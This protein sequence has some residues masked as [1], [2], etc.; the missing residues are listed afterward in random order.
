MNYTLL[1]TPIGTL[2][3]CS[4]RSHLTAIEFPGQHGD[5]GKQPLLEGGCLLLTLLTM[6]PGDDHGARGERHHQD[7]P[8][9]I[10]PRRQDLIADE[11]IDD[12]HDSPGSGAEC[13]RELGYPSG[14]KVGDGTVDEAH[15]RQ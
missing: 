9:R 5:A 6:E 15:E 11:L 12:L 14:S 7:Q 1:D 8:E 4:N 10:H 3:L 2:R 13:G